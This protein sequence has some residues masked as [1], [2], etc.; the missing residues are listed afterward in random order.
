MFIQ[1]LRLR[2]ILSFADCSIDL[3]KLNVVIG[4][5]GSG[6][7]NLTHIVA[8]LANL[9]GDFASYVVNSRGAD[10]WLRLSNG[11]ESAVVDVD[12]EARDNNW[13]YSLSFGAVGP[14]P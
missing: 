14:V 1:R 11:V 5:N 3:R 4:P 7:S 9:P 6:K 10:L 13:T 8:L 12:F 2:N